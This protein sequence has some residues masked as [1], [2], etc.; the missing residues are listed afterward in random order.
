MSYRYCVNKNYFYII[1]ILFFLFCDITAPLMGGPLI[2]FVLEI[3]FSALYLVRLWRLLILLCKNPF[4]AACGT[5][6]GMLVSITWSQ[7]MNGLETGLAM[8]V[9]TWPVYFSQIRRNRP[10]AFL[11]GVAC[12]LES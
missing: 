2:R 11:I 12:W 6:V 9:V 1:Q 5:S 8:A 3:G 7:L 10:L 4:L